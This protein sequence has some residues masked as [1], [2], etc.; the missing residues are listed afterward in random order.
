[1]EGKL[2][3][4]SWE[5]KGPTLMLFLQGPSHHL[6]CSQAII[7]SCLGQM[8]PQGPDPITGY[9]GWIEAAFAW[10]RSFCLLC[11][12]Q[13]LGLPQGDKR[14]LWSCAWRHATELQQ[15]LLGHGMHEHCLP[16]VLTG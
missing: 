2:R 15:C 3:H 14:N 8:L 13:E 4:Y 16:V 11:W 1:M 9:W 5:D 6:S 7:V 10:M 12:Q